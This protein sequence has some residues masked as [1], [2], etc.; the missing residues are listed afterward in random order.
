[1]EERIPAKSCIKMYFNCGN[2]LDNRPAGI[3]PAEWVRLE[4]GL[5][6]A[7]LQIR[8]Q[9]CDMNLIHVDFEGQRH[10]ANTWAVDLY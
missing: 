10:P 7:G 4:A 2:C 5:T 6:P 9:R 8:C 1:M 3:T